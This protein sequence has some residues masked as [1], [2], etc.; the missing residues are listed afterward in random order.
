MSDTAFAANIPAHVPPH[1]IR[2]VDL[3]NPPGG[4]KDVHLAWKN[5]QDNNPDIFFTPRYGGF[6]VLTRAN[7]VASAFPDAA[8][9]SSDK[10]IGIPQVPGVIAQ[11]PIESDPPLHG[12]YRR[13]INLAVSPRAVRGYADAARKLA[14]D[15][16]EEMKPRGACEF[17]REFAGILPMTIFLRLV[18]LPLED[19]EELMGYT[20]A[21]IRGGTYE[22]KI[23]GLNKTFA[24]LE[25]WINRRRK[26]PGTDLLSQIINMQVDGRP[27]THEEALGEA[28]QVLY[29]GLDTVAGT[30]GFFARYLATHDAHRE[31]LVNDPS[32]IPNAT[33][34]LLRRHSIPT[35][36]R[37]V[38][39]DIRFGDVELRKGDQIMLM[40]AMHG[41]DDRVWAE[42]LEVDFKRETGA[43]HAFGS[44]IHKCPGA[45]LARAELKIYLEEWLKRIPVFHLAPG[46]EPVTLA[47]PVMGIQSLHL[48]W[49]V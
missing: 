15:L 9:F 35:V 45:S 33:E 21:V 26:E 17:M 30:M 11:L 43:S 42:P 14:I 28:A 24:Y 32:L 36:G 22:I 4:E 5:I 41:L 6:W 13:P 39:R 1:L 8:T 12:F 49:P 40:C 2:D 47:G 7:L 19:R 38:T 10:A 25:D 37:R 34:E 23:E 29:G 3:Y 27:A 16:I 18:D 46:K 20:D 44:G 31:M 48:V